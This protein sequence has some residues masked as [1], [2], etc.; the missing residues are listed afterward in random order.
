MTQ[1]AGLNYN[2]SIDAISSATLNGTWSNATNLPVITQ[3]KWDRVVLQEQS[4]TPLPATITVNGA[5]VATRGNP[6]NFNLGVGRI[7][8]ALNASDSAAG[9]SNAR[10]TLYETQPLASYGYAS[11]NPAAPVFGSS[12]GIVAGVNNNPYLG[13][14]Q[15][16]AQMAT[17]LHASYVAAAATANALG[18]NPVDTALAGDAWVTAMN[19]GF[20]MIN[21]YSTANPAGQIDLWD[22]DPLDACCTTPIGY[23]PSKYGSYL[24]ALVLFE[25]ITGVDPRFGAGEQAAQDLGIDP[26]IAVA[27]QN[28]AAMTVA[29]GGATVPEPA[30]LALLALGAAALGWTRR[31]SM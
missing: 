20:A 13:A 6:T 22:G 14:A 31:R 12:T 25:Q 1:Q 5:G 26:A 10:V 16:V 8:N 23:H 27:L 15:P 19:N 30:P 4:F 17:D 28:A 11:A 29:A 9:R 7:V 18:K 2:V 3:S 24:S 21:P